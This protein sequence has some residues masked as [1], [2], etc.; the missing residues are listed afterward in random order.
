MVEPIYDNTERTTMMA[1][2]RQQEY[3]HLCELIKNNL[4]EDILAPLS[5]MKTDEYVAQDIEQQAVLDDKTTN[6]IIK[7]RSLKDILHN[8]DSLRCSDANDRQTQQH[9]DREKQRT[10][11]DILIF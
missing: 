7:I 5:I 11:L 9:V 8:I 10:K 4:I 6:P 3:A 1:R 2:L